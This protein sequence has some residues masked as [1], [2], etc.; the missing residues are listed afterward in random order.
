MIAARKDTIV[1]L[2]CLACLAILATWSLRLG[3]A[4]YWAGRGGVTDLE[5]AIA[6]TPDQAPYYVRLAAR[7]AL[8][9]PERSIAA[10]RRATALNPAD[11][12][13]WVALGLQLEAVNN[14]DEAEQCLLR[15][16]EE[17]HLFLPRWVLANFYFRRNNPARFW[18]WAKASATMVYGDPQPLFRLCGR[19]AED[20]ELIS[21]LQIRDPELQIRYLSYLLDQDRAD[22]AGP[23]VRAVLD[24]QRASAV[25]VLLRTCDQL[26]DSRRVAEALEIWN[27]LADARWIPFG[28][29]IPGSGTT[30]TNGDFQS[31]LGLGG[32]DW[33]LPRIEGVSASRETS[34]PGLRIQFSG[35]Q[36]ESCEPL[37][38]IVPV[39]ENAEYELTFRY[40]TS[41]IAPGTGLGW[42][43]SD[44]RGRIIRGPADNISSA[45]EMQQRITFKTP[46]GT[47]AVRIS[48]AYDR[49]IGTTR[50][51]GW[52]ALSGAR[53]TPIGRSKPLGRR[54]SQVIDKN[55]DHDKPQSVEKRL[56]PPAHPPDGAGA[57]AN[58]LIGIRGGWGSDLPAHEATTAVPAAIVVKS[59]ITKQVLPDPT[60]VGTVCPFRFAGLTKH[61]YIRRQERRNN[62]EYTTLLPV[63]SS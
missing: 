46:H 30:L 49:A 61:S 52:I 48:F 4:D 41:G 33:R 62:R 63:L 58:G 12:E 17:S 3:W 34:P 36:P 53:L 47:P 26:L 28:P 45:G 14:L 20:G 7:L 27:R 16:A 38:Q 21:R 6:I 59:E 50:I 60:A 8:D 37:S 31:S 19:A 25:P 13:S 18:Q 5:R 56:S 40:R 1:A 44:L 15:A 54:N 23:A 57:A 11:A 2:G 43:V 42:R 39:Q 22:L 10:L 24:G 29:L 35:R 32:F 55:A 51:E 9:E